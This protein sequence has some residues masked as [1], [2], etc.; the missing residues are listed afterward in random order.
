MIYA[1]VPPFPNIKNI[2]IRFQSIVFNGF[3]MYFF[4]LYDI[5]VTYFSTPE[6]F[7][8]QIV[9][10]Q[11]YIQILYTTHTFFYFRFKKILGRYVKIKILSTISYIFT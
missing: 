7:I 8:K 3:D 11:L 2:I 10:K 1:H 5:F 9:Y 6:I 4:F